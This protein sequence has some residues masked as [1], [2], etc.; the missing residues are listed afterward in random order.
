MSINSTNLSRRLSSPTRKTSSLR[1]GLLSLNQK[2]LKNEL[3]RI[4]LSRRQYET[5]YSHEQR[6]VITRFATKLIR[7]TS[8][9]D[10][11]INQDNSI[12]NSTC[13]TPTYQQ[14]N[15]TTNSGFYEPRTQSIK[16]LL[17]N[18]DNLS[19]TSSVEAIRVKKSV[20][21]NPDLFSKENSEYSDTSTIS[22][23]I[24]QKSRPTFYEINKKYDELKLTMPNPTPNVLLP[25]L[26]SVNRRP[27]SELTNFKQNNALFLD[28]HKS[29]L[30]N[31]NKFLNAL[32][33]EESGFHSYQNCLGYDNFRNL[34]SSGT[35]LASKE[36]TNT[37]KI[38]I[39]KNPFNEIE[40]SPPQTPSKFNN[41]T[42]NINK[43]NDFQHDKKRINLNNNNV[44]RNTP[45]LD[46]KNQ[47]LLEKKKNDD[48]KMCMDTFKAQNIRSL[49]FKHI[50][51]Y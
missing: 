38:K 30:E 37:E 21:W 40:T 11:I 32:E 42:N 28:V 5:L 22:L 1:Q 48:D 24:N 16:S 13:T 39:F 46:I 17:K 41:S 23:T 8:T 15:T 29:T 34:L 45:D 18:N 6:K 50:T 12:N 20:K 43:K 51:T 19:E 9:L 7:S 47:L 49:T 3:K 35:N 25:Q 10:N 44:K 4:D 27:N 2:E 14:R 31:K 33:N 26:I 36:L